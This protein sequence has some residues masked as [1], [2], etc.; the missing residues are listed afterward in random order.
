MVKHVTQVKE[1]LLRGGTLLQVHLAPFGDE[2]GD[3]H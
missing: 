3:I 2:F 1:M